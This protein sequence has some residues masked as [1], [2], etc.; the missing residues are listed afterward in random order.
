MAKKRSVCIHGAKST[1]V[2]SPRSPY[3]RRQL[4]IETAR[5]EGWAYATVRSGPD[6]RVV[7][8]S[9]SGMVVGQ[10][11]MHLDCYGD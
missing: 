8:D 9:V 1:R 7:T 6:T 5:R 11:H 2:V 4:V 3:H 10:P